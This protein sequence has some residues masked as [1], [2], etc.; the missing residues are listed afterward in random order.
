MY[1]SIMNSSDVAKMAA[2]KT[3]RGLMETGL[4]RQSNWMIAVTQ[5]DKRNTL[6]ALVMW[7][8]DMDRRGYGQT[9]PA[10]CWPRSV[11]DVYESM[12]GG[13]PNPSS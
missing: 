7:V 8:L 11:H 10:A 1:L 2:E 12:G 4:E 9:L 13:K 5:A 6:S 3:F